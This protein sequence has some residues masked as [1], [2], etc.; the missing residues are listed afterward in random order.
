VRG[1]HGGVI[2][3]PEKFGAHML[4]MLVRAAFFCPAD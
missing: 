1:S 4:E 2:N 3:D